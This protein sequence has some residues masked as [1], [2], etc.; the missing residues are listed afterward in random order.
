MQILCFIEIFFCVLVF[1][2][3]AEHF[4]LNR[5]H[6]QGSFFLLLLEETRVATN[7]S[8]VSILNKFIFILIYTHKYRFP[9]KKTQPH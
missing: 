1:P 8:A 3:K 5:N 2:E 7:Q 4:V 9:Q 6:S